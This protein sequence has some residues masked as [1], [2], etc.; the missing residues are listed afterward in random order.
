MNKLEQARKII[1]EVD[2]QM[3]QLFEKRMQAS[4]LV[5]E[6]KKEH[7]VSILDEQR[8]KE[9]IAKKIRPT[10]FGFLQML[11]ISLRIHC[12]RARCFHSRLL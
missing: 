8:E 7:G 9:V 12:E 3:A 11:P 4:E 5:A 6:Y 2:K 1:N 10:N